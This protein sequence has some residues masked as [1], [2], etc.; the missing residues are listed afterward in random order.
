MTLRTKFNP[1][2]HELDAKFRL[3][4]YTGKMGNCLIHRMV[5]FSVIRSHC[6][7]LCP[8]NVALHGGACKVPSDVLNR[9]LEELGGIDQFQD[10]Q[11]LG[12]MIIPKMG[13]KLIE[14]FP[15]WFKI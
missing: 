6:N 14:K 2:A 10:D 4:K 3:T 7:I 1:E 13:K 12:G 11:F 8:P 5:L 9:L 15:I